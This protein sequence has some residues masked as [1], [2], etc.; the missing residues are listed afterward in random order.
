[1]T[2][3]KLG[4]EDIH[5]R[6]SIRNEAGLL[7]HVPIAPGGPFHLHPGLVQLLSDVVAEDVPDILLEMMTMTVIMMMVVMIMVMKI[8]VI[9]MMHLL[10]GQLLAPHLEQ[11]QLGALTGQVEEV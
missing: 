3:E 5:L 7:A 9:M 2:Q 6:K 10:A 4:C 11:L 1:M 8:M